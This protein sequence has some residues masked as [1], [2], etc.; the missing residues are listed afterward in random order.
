MKTHTTEPTCPGCEKKLTLAHP[1]LKTWFN[2]F[3]KLNFKTAH[4]SDSWRGEKEQNLYHAEGRSNAAFPNSPHNH[5]DEN[6]SP[7][8][9]ALDLFELCSN[10]MPCWSWLY[11]KHIFELS[12]KEG[13]PIAWGGYFKL[14]QARHDGPHFEID[15]G[16]CDIEM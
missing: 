16:K 6:G 14:P 10:D 9:Y 3:V 7:Q 15:V 12:Q 8:S 2:D 11:F 1:L 13:Y 4:I 5:V